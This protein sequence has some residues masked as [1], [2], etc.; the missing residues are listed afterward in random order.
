[1][2]LVGNDTPHDHVLWS[3]TP[4]F[5]VNNTSLCGLYKI[6]GGVFDHETWSCGVSFPTNIMG[7]SMFTRVLD[8]P[9]AQGRRSNFFQKTLLFQF[10]WNLFCHPMMLQNIGV[11]VISPDEF[12]FYKVASEWLCKSLNPVSENKVQKCT[13]LVSFADKTCKYWIKLAQ[14]FLLFL[15]ICVKSLKTYLDP[16]TLFKK[17]VKLF[18]L[19]LSVVFSMS[20]YWYHQFLHFAYHKKM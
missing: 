1:M 6:F 18:L 13:T 9:E 2:I 14:F 3:K 8:L 15:S 17:P 16:K 7:L 12:I 11:Y 5:L 10:H 20:Y 19:K 4:H